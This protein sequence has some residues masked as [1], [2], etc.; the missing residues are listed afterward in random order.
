MKRLSHLRWLAPLLLAA[1]APTSWGQAGLPAKLTHPDLTREAVQ[2]VGLRD[3]RLSYFD[4]NRAL[5]EADA[6]DLVELRLGGDSPSEVDMN[7]QQRAV[8][9][10]ADGQRFYGRWLQSGRDTQEE[11]GTGIAW[12][13]ATMGRLRVPLDRVA[14]IA[15]PPNAADLLAGQAGLASDVVVLT[16]GDRVG[17]F[18]ESITDEQLRLLPDGADA[19]VALPRDRVRAVLLANPPIPLPSVGYLVTLRDGTRVRAQT[20]TLTR[21][22]AEL[23]LPTDLRPD[24]QP[25]EAVETV[26]LAADQITAVAML[27]SGLR[28][29]DLTSLPR[30]VT[31]GGEVF[32]LPAAPVVEPEGSLW[33]HAPVELVFRLPPGAVRFAAD[34]ELALDDDVPAAARPL[35]DV[36]ITADGGDAA[37]QVTLD[38]D[39]PRERLGTSLTTDILRLHIDPAA[40]GPILDR[41]RLRNA[42]VLVQTTAR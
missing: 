15:Q 26:Q 30:E 28:L 41:V 27:D 9:M 22:A 37:S 35:A 39:H 1:L 3:G 19:A 5:R 2:L 11:E 38:A 13:H 17:G 18:V 34:A 8:L 40:R 24:S 31:D 32:G 33:L 25:G 23:T 36:N 12:E 7:P 29:I 4:S 16:N 42:R 6:K 20:F 14:G 10:L 21:D